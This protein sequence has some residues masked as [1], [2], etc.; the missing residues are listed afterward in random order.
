MTDLSGKTA[1]VAGSTSGIGEV[2]AI[3]VA[4][5]DGH[6][7]IHYDPLGGRGPR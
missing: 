1:L 3:A 7:D 2:T 4:A 6:V 5:R